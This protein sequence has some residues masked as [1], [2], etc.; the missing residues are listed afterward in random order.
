MHPLLHD[1]AS[2]CDRRLRSA[3]VGATVLIV[4]APLASGTS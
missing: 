4:D 1:I 3:A 2:Y